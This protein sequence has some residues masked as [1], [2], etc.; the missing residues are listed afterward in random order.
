MRYPYLRHRQIGEIDKGRNRRTVAPT[1]PP[2]PKKGRQPKARIQTQTTDRD[3]PPKVR[4]ISQKHDVGTTPQKSKLISERRNHSRKQGQPPIRVNEKQNETMIQIQKQNE[5]QNKT[6]QNLNPQTQHLPEFR[7][8]HSSQWFREYVRR[9]FNAWN[10]V[11][12]E[13]SLLNMITYPMI[14]TVHMF[15]GRLVLWVFCNLDG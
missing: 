2:R 15:H 12:P 7:E 5:K 13:G 1:Q 14:H 6:K 3:N 8:L 9:V 11:D 10:V 4:I